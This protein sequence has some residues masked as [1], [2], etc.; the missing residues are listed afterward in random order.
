[1]TTLTAP[2]VMLNWREA[3][4][5][6][7]RLVDAFLTGAPAAEVGTVTVPL[8]TRARNEADRL[9]DLALGLRDARA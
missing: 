9:M 7:G 4:D 2:Q 3:E 8:L 6:F 1:M 5:R